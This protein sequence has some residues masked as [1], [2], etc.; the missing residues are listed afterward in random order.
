M[1]RLFY[2][3]ILLGTALLAA[4]SD[5]EK[6][7]SGT[8]I[9]LTTQ[10]Q[11][12]AFRERGYADMLIISGEDI[13][14]LSALS[15]SGVGTLVIQK[16][17]IETLS[18]P[19]LQSVG[20]EFTV[21]N[22]NRLTSIADLNSLASVEGAMLINNNAR[23]NDISGLLSIE[24]IAGQLS[25][26]NNTVLG[27]DKP[28]DGDDYR[29]GLLPVRYLAEHDAL[30]GGV[31]LANNHPLSATDP[32]QI[33]TGGIGDWKDFM[34]SSKNEAEAF[35]PEGTTVMNLTVK[36]PEITDE[37]L[38]SL[39]R[40]GL[41]CVK[42]T[43]TVENTKITN[44]EGF[45][46]VVQCAGSIVFRDNHPDQGQINTN[47]LR[48]Y[49]RI[50]GDL[51]IENTA[52]VFWTNASSFASIVEI[53]GDLRVTDCDDL[54]SGEGFESLKTVGGDVQITRCR[55]IWNLAGMKIATIGGSLILL[56][57]ERFNGL[58]GLESVQ[59]IGGTVKI[60]GELPDY[61]EV[62]RPGWC[63]V[64]KWI[65]DRFMTDTDNM[66]LLNK[67][68]DAVSLEGIEP[69]DG[70]NP[71][72]ANEPKN[73][74]ING[75]SELEAFVSAI[76]VEKETV[77]DLTITGEDIDTDMMSRVQGRVGTVKGTVTWD[78]LSVETTEH[79]FEVIDCQGGIVIRNCANLGNPN[80]FEKYT[81]V[82]GDFILEN[83]PKLATPASPGWDDHGWSFLE[84]VEGT[85][86]LQGLAQQLGGTAFKRLKT[87]GGN[88]E[89]VECGTSF[90]DLNNMPLSSVGGSI[91]VM[92]N[93]NLE[94]LVGLDK[95]TFIGGDVMILDNPKVPVTSDWAVGYCMLR[96]YLT[97][98]IIRPDATVK[99]GTTDN[100]IDIA[101]VP[102]CSGD[103]LPTEPQ[104]Y[105]L[106]GKSMVE[107]FINGAAAE[108]ETVNDLTI[109]GADVTDD[110]LSRIQNRVGTI[111][112]TVTWDGVAATTT[113]N[114]FEKIECRGGIVIRNCENLGNPNGFEGYT[115]IQGDFII[116]NC[117]NLA[118]PGSPGWAEHG[119]YF[120][121]HVGGTFRLMGVKQQMGADNTFHSLK[122]VGGNFEIVECSD[123]FWNFTGMPLTS[124]GG[125][126]IVT[127]NK[128]LESLEGL[129]KL[130][131]IGGDVMI[132][133]NP[134]APRQSSSW[135]VGMC[136]FKHY[137]DTGVIAP[138]ATITLGTTEQ[139]IDVDELT[140]CTGKEEE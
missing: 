86:R 2:R 68:G 44:T 35:D 66:E 84:H 94:N 91:I 73:Y 62:G 19:S 42:G 30:Q 100:P 138:Q 131:R 53:A 22:N 130:T 99:I 120:L 8:D 3:T 23:L 102:S 10:S 88:F 13:T 82:H 122:S 33:G 31:K 50:G 52:L 101:T 11:V 43:M 4:C 90:W 37:V 36:G 139:S 21:E 41:R 60:R 69:C 121:E 40:K 81:A 74:T 111:Q 109:S 105:V 117:P 61:G 104:N 29:Y 77:I 24:R 136:I 7:V 55:N 18:L 97:R 46:D 45:F 140:P 25:I 49:T 135:Q 28:L 132:F 27:E 20:R 106:N 107:A 54:G 93:P 114:F 79:F 116:E 127:G 15:I 124:I 115:E 59:K 137:K 16:T 119:W 85:V 17:S 80:G 14:D 123:A 48:Y 1:K 34:I 83:C 108:K 57:N 110:L 76:P 5:S 65:T 38:I 126:L 71:D 87:V 92:N 96:D 134:K 64:K 78:N 58:G 39:T 125:S 89:I 133:D 75:K 63:L 72:G 128:N 98:G 6:S 70:F 56:E 95:L 112:G 12:N 32:T 26:T 47:G 113:V 51:I 103:P 9:R 129:E 118:T 67:K